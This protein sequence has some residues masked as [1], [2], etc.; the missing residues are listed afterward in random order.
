MVD[1][2]MRIADML[3]LHVN[4]IVD[5]HFKYLNQFISL[6]LSKNPKAERSLRIT[7]LFLH[8]M[9]DLNSKPIDSVLNLY[10]ILHKNILKDSQQ[11]LKWMI[12]LLESFH[13]ND[14]CIP[15]HHGTTYESM[16]V[17]GSR[18]CNTL[19][20]PLEIFIKSL[21]HVCNYFFIVGIGL[22]SF[23]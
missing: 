14:C 16:L 22:S 8:I 6:K 4:D 7:L 1:F 11:G 21:E 2:M 18:H 17:T 20:F 10:K 15:H 19:G 3:K 12:L 13:L 9:M 23:Y 5:F